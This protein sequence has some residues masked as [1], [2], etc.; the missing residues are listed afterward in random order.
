MIPVVMA[1]KLARVGWTCR[2]V[3]RTKYMRKT[4]VRKHYR[5]RQS[6]RWENNVKIVDR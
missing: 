4:C 3:E 1:I 5:K 6:Y 2:W